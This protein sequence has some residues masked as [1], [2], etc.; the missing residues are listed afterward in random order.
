MT[1]VERELKRLI[2][3]HTVEI[4]RLSNS[5]ELYKYENIALLKKELA[6]FI[7]EL[8]YLKA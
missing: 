2:T 7:N 5:S 8:N 6:L 4:K 3:H 1:I